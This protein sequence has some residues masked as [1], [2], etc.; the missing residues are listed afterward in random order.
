[1][2][3]VSVGLHAASLCIN[4]RLY[5]IASM[6]TIVI[7][8]AEKRR[9][10]LIDSLTFRL[11]PGLCVA[12]QYIVRGHRFDILEDIG[13]YPALFNSLPT[14][15]IPSMWPLLIGH[16]SGVHCVLS[17]RAFSLR[18][19]A[20]VLTAHPALTP[21]RYLRFSA[22]A[23]IDLL[24]TAPRRLHHRPQPHRL[25]ARAPGLLRRHSLRLWTRGDHPALRV[26]RGR[27]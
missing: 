8:E 17:L 23:L 7:T 1:M 12:A 11:F 24:L 13:C 27:E 21:V 4:R 18:C 20:F 6:R 22:L 5:H 26:G 9:V 2:M 19:A 15:F 16:A 10:V 25:P 14:Y 3:G